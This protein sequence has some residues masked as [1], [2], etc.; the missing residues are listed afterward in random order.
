MRIPREIH[1]ADKLDRPA[2][3]RTQTNGVPFASVSGLL[4]LSRLSAWWVALGIDLER[5]RPGHPQD[6]GAHERMHVDLAADVEATPAAS[7]PLQQ[8]ACDRWRQV[9]NHV[10]PHDAL[11]GKTPADVYRSSP[12]RPR[13]RAPVYPG[14]F[15]VR[16]VAGCGTVKIDGEHYFVTQSVAGYHIGLEPLGGLR[17]RVWFYDMDLGELEVADP[18]NRTLSLVATK[19]HIYV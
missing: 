11:A 5:G 6:N 2:R 4:G 15:I 12:T 13:G 17:H 8:R 10:R 9:F 1:H 3:E 14:H 16:H 18:R 19:D 7:L